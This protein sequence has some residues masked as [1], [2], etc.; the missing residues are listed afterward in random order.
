MVGTRA[1][2]RAGT[3]GLSDQAPAP[4]SQTPVWERAF[5]NSVSRV[6]ES[7]QMDFVGEWM[8]RETEF[9]EVRS[10]TEFG[11]EARR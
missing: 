9:P 8:N 5:G 4:R 6:I 10:Q 3:G 1:A 7:E 11:N 2:A